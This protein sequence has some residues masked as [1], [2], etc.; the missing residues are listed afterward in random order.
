MPEEPDHP[1]PKF[2]PDFAPTNPVNKIAAAANKVRF[3]PRNR[4]YVDE[5]G[6]L[7]FDRFGQKY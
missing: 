7:I 3:D 2:D 5:E 4:A 6:S 1:K